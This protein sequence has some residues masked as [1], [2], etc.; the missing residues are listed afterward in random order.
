MPFDRV[1]LIAGNGVSP[2][3]RDRLARVLS[4]PAPE[5]GGEPF[6][7]VEPY[8]SD[9]FEQARRH[10]TLVV[11]ASLSVT[12]DVTRRVREALTAEQIGNASAHHGSFFVL[13]DAWGRGQVAVV[14]AAVDAEGLL[15]IVEER[16]E[17]IRGVLFGA[18]RDKLA[19]ELFA[20]GEDVAAT[21]ALAERYGWSVRIPAHGW[22]IDSSRAGQGAV[23][24]R[25]SDGNRTLA[26]AW[27]AEPEPALALAAPRAVYARLAEQ[28]D[29]GRAAEVAEGDFEPMQ[30][31]ARSGFEVR[32]AWRDAE[33]RE[34]GTLHGLLFAEPPASR[35][36]L[37][38]CRLA[39]GSDGAKLG[40]LELDALATT[41]HT[42]S[43]GYAAT[44]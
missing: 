8:G 3:A 4:A 40:G 35:V 16:D 9:R 20:G 1:A 11:L 14:V 36:Y 38:E 28:L 26:V 7:V 17:R 30:R 23:A 13:E 42:A 18:V 33:G 12:G 32:A 43:E 15:G 25:S 21:R 5:A 19:D 37:L 6:F 24:I 10:R 41:F 34:A 27:L 2:A 39:G 22:A 29:V 31:G 44:R